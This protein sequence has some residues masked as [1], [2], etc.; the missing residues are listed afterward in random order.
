MFSLPLT[1][2]R[3]NDKCH[4]CKTSTNGEHKP[5]VHFLNVQEMVE[6]YSFHYFR[7]DIPSFVQPFKIH[8]CIFWI[9]KDILVGWQFSSFCRLCLTVTV[10]RLS[11]VVEPNTLQCAAERSHWFLIDG[12]WH[13]VYWC[14]TKHFYADRLTKFVYANGNLYMTIQPCCR[15][16]KSNKKSANL[17][18]NESKCIFDIATACKRVSNDN[19]M[20]KLK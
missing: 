19:K 9:A 5:I 14:S 1:H 2:N 20:K 6:F 4:E 8:F 15:M 18:L 7:K 10:F 17:L 11:K 13:I 3:T 12:I 16:R